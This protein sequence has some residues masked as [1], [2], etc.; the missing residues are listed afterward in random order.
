M[1]FLW[2]GEI[3]LVPFRLSDV[4]FWPTH[5]NNKHTLYIYSLSEANRESD[6]NW[7]FKLANI[8]F[9]LLWTCSGTNSVV[10]LNCSLKK[11]PKRLVAG[12]FISQKCFSF[13]GLRSTDLLKSFILQQNVILTSHR[14]ITND[15]SWML[16]IEPFCWLFQLLLTCTIMNG[17][18]TDFSK[19]CQTPPPV[20]SRASP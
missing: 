12:Y 20:F 2:S 10:Q 11:A 13:W 8:D 17:F 19:N 6:S 9:T 5:V 18:K 15:F 14:I 7:I 1:S 16:A 3:G 4:V